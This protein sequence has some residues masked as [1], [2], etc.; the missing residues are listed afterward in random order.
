MPVC[1]KGGRHETHPAGI[2]WRAI[3]CEFVKGAVS[4]C[5]GDF[6]GDCPAGNV[7]SEARG[8]GLYLGDCHALADY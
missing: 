2:D 5:A 6:F 4:K 8:V 7:I 1:L 3:R